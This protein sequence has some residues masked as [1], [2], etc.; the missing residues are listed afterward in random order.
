MKLRKYAVIC[1]I[2]A[3]AMILPLSTM[4]ATVLSA[5]F[6]APDYVDP[7]I[8]GLGQQ[9]PLSIS[10]DHVVGEVLNIKV[11]DS[12]TGK[13]WES[14]PVFTSGDKAGTTEAKSNELHSQIVLT[15]TYDKNGSADKLAD[16]GYVASA[17][18]EATFFSHQESVV[19]NQLT[20]YNILDNGELLSYY[21]D[22][23]ADPL[24]LSPI[25]AGRTVVGYK[26]IYGFGDRDTALSPMMITESRMDQFVSQIQVFAEDG[27]TLDE[28]ATE[29]MKETLLK[30]YRH[31]NYESMLEDI[32]KKVKRKKT[33]AEKEA[34]RKQLEEELDKYVAEYPIIMTE[35]IY[36]LYSDAISTT[37]NKKLLISYWAAAGYTR[38]DLESD[39]QMVGYVS[40]SG[41][42]AFDVP[43]EYIIE[44]STFRASVVTDEIVYPSEVGIT[45]LNF[46]PGFGAADDTVVEGYSLVPDGCGALIP[47][48]AEDQRQTGYQVPVIGRHRDE[49]LSQNGRDY[50]DI[51]YY[52]TTMLPVFGQKQDDN[53]FFCIIE[54]GYEFS[55]VVAYVADRFTKYNTAFA[56]FFPTVTDDIYY[57][58]GSTSGIKMFPKVEVE[59]I[60]TRTERSIDKETGEVVIEEVVKAVVN[61]YCRLPATNLTLRYSF[62]SG[63]KADYV[64]MAEYY[65]TYLMNT[66]GMEKLEA[67]DSTAF[68][69]DLYGIMDKKVSYVGF[70]IN[71]K[72]ALTTFEEAE[73]IVNGLLGLGVE[74]LTVRYVGMI[75]GGL[76]QRYAGSFKVERNLGGKSG[77]KDFLTSMSALGVNV[78]P[79]ID[80]IHVYQDRL[81]DGFSPDND[82]VITLGKTESI[83]FDTN[84]ATGRKDKL[85]DSEYYHP[86]WVVSPKVYEELF[87]EIDE[88][89]QDFDNKNVSFGTLGYR[90]ASDYDLDMII[91]RGQS[92]RVVA[93][94]LRQLEESGYDIMVERGFVYTLPYVSTVLNIP[95]TSS[96]FTVALNDVPFMQMV[97]HGLIEFAGEP[98]NVTQ[99]V[100]YN[101]LKCLEYGAGVYARFMHEDDSVFQNT[102]FLNLFSMNYKNWMDEAKT[103]YS[104]VNAAIG[105]V[106]NQFIVDHECLAENV[107]RTTYEGGK[108][109]IVNYNTADFVIEELG[110]TVGARNYVVMGGAQ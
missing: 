64:G 73:E 92:A 8:E 110:V 43:V 46:L 100:Q 78:Y 49:A 34:L 61:N 81:F 50:S 105:D 57:A 62:L 32:E 91:D 80:A 89:L 18:T 7:Y 29:K 76:N 84:I 36:E 55:N 107:Y 104:E 20:I 3:L 27:V 95:M 4:A 86:R 106:Q 94:Q 47:V 52:E 109:V 65:R 13:V 82:T 99:D 75:N 38:S 102:Y 96:D 39:H 24:E 21:V 108:Q 93:D 19:K 41:G 25:T 79:D 98:F 2:L 12:R 63:D 101:I 87:D 10:I 9:S 11:T 6:V 54:E 23:T 103:I 33:D 22:A 35:G 16:I 37:R 71:T 40:N 70:P 17:T 72:Y 51:P 28:E 66:H 85:E 69:A 15:Y 58:S 60:E 83:I 31:V 56:A 97:I 1:Y 59:E 44:G 42:V 77:Y 14:N 53:A 26:V 45:R 30:K 90:L 5:E 88:N 74:D 68:Y 48:N 67:T